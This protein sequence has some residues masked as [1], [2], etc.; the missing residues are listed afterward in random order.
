MSGGLFLLYN[1]T[2]T[3]HLPTTTAK[4]VTATPLSTSS[5]TITISK[6][7]QL[8]FGIKTVAVEMKPMVSGLE[9]N[10]LVRVLP[11]AQAALSAPL[12][13]LLRIK[14]ALKIG[15]LV[16]KGEPLAKIEQILTVADQVSLETYR[17]E[18]R[19]R[20]TQALDQ[21]DHTR[22]Q[23]VNANIELTRTRKLYELGA[24][25][26]RELQ[27]V[28][29]RVQLAT[30]E[31]AHAQQTLI[32]VNAQDEYKDPNSTIVLNAPF[33]G[34]VAT[35][36]GVSGEQVEAGK[37]ILTLVDLSSVW[38][39][40][41]LFENDLSKVLNSQQASY[42][43]P[44]LGNEIRTA[45]AQGA[46]LLTVATNINPTTR[47][48][49]AYFKV[50]NPNNLMRDGMVAEISLDTSEGRDLLIIPKQA[51]VED[52]TEKIVFIYKGGES[53]ARRAVEVAS[54]GL[55]EVAISKGLQTG[56]RVVIEGLSQLRSSSGMKQGY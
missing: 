17:L 55:N 36:N 5:N 20:R 37:A 43:I 7:S 18:Q 23:L 3:F 16:Q 47:S 52:Q 49:A 56:E 50:A 28:E 41:Q 24:I 31:A 19:T 51:L 13:G 26:L 29:Q 54:V 46:P 21:A 32:D 6:E 2:K 22:Q 48:I 34:F 44:A 27:E 39:E 12:T 1:L 25:S 8:R 45:I 11:Q 4:V 53:F 42:R 33:T 30:A 15:D 9:V 35:I 38:I 40:A 10:G 14:P